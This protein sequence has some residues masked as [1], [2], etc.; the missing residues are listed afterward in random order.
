MVLAIPTT[1]P[2]IEGQVG[3]LEN[4]PFLLFIDFDLVNFEELSNPLTVPGD[5]D[6]ELSLVS[7]L[8]EADVQIIL[9][10]HCESETPDYLGNAGIQIIEGMQGDALAAL[11]KFRKYCLDQ[12]QIMTA[13]QLEN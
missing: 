9:V 12:T 11:G 13:V 10:D 7:S 1:Q 8:V 4:S 2:G 5:P 3:H 6:R